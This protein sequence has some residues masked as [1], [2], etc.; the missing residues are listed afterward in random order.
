MKFYMMKY[1]NVYILLVEQQHGSSNDESVSLFPDIETSI[2]ASF[3][4]PQQVMESSMEDA[5]PM[6]QSYMSIS[7]VVT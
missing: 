2:E 3:E 4:V 6:E 1:I 7:T 5:T